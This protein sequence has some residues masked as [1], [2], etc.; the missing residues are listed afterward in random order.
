MPRPVVPEQLLQAYLDDPLVH[1][2]FELAA[3]RGADEVETLT[4]LV[5]ELVKE[6]KRIVDAY[7]DHMMRC[8]LPPRIV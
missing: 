7:T 5:L 3:Q 1:A 6:K 4:L 2:V 8:A